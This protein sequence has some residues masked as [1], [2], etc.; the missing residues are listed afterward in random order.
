[1]VEKNKLV[2]V[3]VDDNP[4]ALFNLESYLQLIPEVV[5]AGKATD[6]RKAIK[7]I[8]ETCPD[9]LFLDIEMP[10][11]NGFEL[12]KIIQEENENRQFGVI[13]HTAY[14]KY[15]LKALR[16][17]AFDYILKP[18]KEEEIRSAVKR[19][20]E[21]KTSNKHVAEVKPTFIGKNMIALPTTIG[22]QFISK[23]DI[24]Y[25]ECNKYKGCS[26]PSW[27]VMLNNQQTIRLRNNANSESIIDYL[28][29]SEFVP[30]SQSVIVN[31]SYVN[32]I[33]YKTRL[34]Y[35]FPPF[36]ETPLLVSR[37]YLAEMRERYDVL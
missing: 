4:E 34:C 17:N 31:L 35:L 8:N 5:I 18:P 10:G 13:F 19:Y 6:Y 30:L 1:M 33:E 25:I 27:M 14:D 7:L 29:S 11:K 23:S 21:M 3:I 15:T 37:Q 28:G 32:T 36:Y 22:L 20:L 26:R 9:L 2:V 24:V 12:L 16:E